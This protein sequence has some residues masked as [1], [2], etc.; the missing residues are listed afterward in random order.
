M[1]AEH[2]VQDQEQGKYSVNLLIK[3]HILIT[4]Y[5]HVYEGDKKAS[6]AASLTSNEWQKGCGRRNWFLNTFLMPAAARRGF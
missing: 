1:S 3:V 2:S 6:M 4:I 5:V